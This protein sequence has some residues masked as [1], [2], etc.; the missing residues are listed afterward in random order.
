MATI[1]FP[2]MCPDS[3]FL[4]SLRLSL[5]PDLPMIMDQARTEEERQI[6]RL[7]FARQVMAGPCVALSDVPA[8]RV[9]ALRRAFDDTMKNRDFLAEADKLRLEMT[10]GSGEKT[11]RPITEIDQTKTPALAPHRLRLVEDLR[12]QLAQSDRGVEALCGILGGIGCDRLQV[13]AEL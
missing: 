2:E 9:A 7:M 4:T 5:H 3:P 13:P 6:F 1:D 10:P 8:E 12:G 11:H